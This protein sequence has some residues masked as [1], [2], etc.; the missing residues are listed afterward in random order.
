[1]AATDFGFSLSFLVRLSI[2]AVHLFKLCNELKRIG[3]S[4]TTRP[5]FTALYRRLAS[6]LVLSGFLRL[7]AF[8]TLANA[9]ILPSPRTPIYSR[10]LA[11][12][13]RISDVVH[14]VFSSCITFLLIFC[15]AFSFIMCSTIRLNSLNEHYHVPKRISRA[16]CASDRH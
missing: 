9:S 11:Y 14:E 8:L 10:L 2:R 12:R 3:F 13:P 4:D 16:I 7:L 1:M 6:S 5:F 15:R